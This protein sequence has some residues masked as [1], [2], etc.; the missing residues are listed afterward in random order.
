MIQVKIKT[1]LALGITNLGRV[2]FYRLG[3]KLGLNPVKTITEGVES[4]VFFKE[5]S[6][7]LNVRLKPNTQ[8]LDQQCYFGWQTKNSSE[9]PNWHQSI[10]TGTSVKDPK[11]PWWEIPDFDPDLGDIKGVWEASRFDWVLG[12]S[13]QVALGDKRHLDKLNIW[14][15]DWLIHNPPYIGVNWKCGQEASVRVMHLAMA[16]VILNQTTN[17]SKTLLSLIKAHLKRISPTI[18]YAIAQDNN[19]GTSEA[20]ALYIGGSWLLKNNDEDGNKWLKQGE[21]W[22][23]NRAQ[24]L[25]ED[26]GS[27]SQYSVTYH[28]LMLDTYSI[29]EVWRTDLELKPLDNIIYTKLQLATLWLFN[30]TQFETGDAPNLGANDGARLLPLTET[31]YRDFRPSIQLA[32]TLFL[33]KSAYAQ[34]GDWDLPLYWLKITKPEFSIEKPTSIDMPIGGYAILRNQ[35]A[36]ALLNY[37]KFKFRPSQCDVLHL[38]FW[39]R[40]ENLLRDGGTFSYNAGQTYIDYYGGTQSHNTIQFDGHQQM[41]RLSRFLLGNWLKTR[42]KKPL[43]SNN[44]EVTFSAAYKDR[45]N[46]LHQRNITLTTQRLVVTDQVKGFNKNAILRWRLKP[47]N[48]LLQDQTISM[49]DHIISINSDV[50]FARIALIEGQESRYYYQEQVIPIIEIEINQPGTITTEYIFKQ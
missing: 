45:F 26:D 44:T 34:S 48:W 47:G 20:A 28:R 4:G 16:T 42:F 6:N 2:L 27:F 46:C 31:D 39:L 11:S 32:A 36:F 25:I 40:G 1:A 50:K 3:V 21:K 14:L 12:F 9:T 24:N 22:L 35:Y 33:K 37:P 29:V 17:T 19:H 41:P 15:N 8:W 30:M 43:K 38:D 10:L 23:K 5:C 13:Q 49:G 7:E 18:S